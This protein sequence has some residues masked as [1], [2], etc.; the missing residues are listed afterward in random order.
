MGNSFNLQRATG[1]YCT[2]TWPLAAGSYKKLGAIREPS[3]S[4]GL[5]GAEAKGSYKYQEEKA[6]GSRIIGK[7]RTK[8]SHGA[9]G[10][11][12]VRTK[13]ILRRSES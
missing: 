3:R 4:G 7:L 10:S 1:N 5:E 9:T 11:F 12:E 2:S 13:K 8:G 6:A